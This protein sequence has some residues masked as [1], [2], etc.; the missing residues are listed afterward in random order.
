MDVPLY[1]IA[2][3]FF[4][5][6]YLAI[7]I[8]LAYVLLVTLFVMLAYLAVRHGKLP[9]NYPHSLGDTL[10][11][12]A[13][14]GVTWLIFVELGPKNPI[15]WSGSGL[16][17]SPSTLIPIDSIIEAALII[18]IIFVIILSFIARD[19]SGAGPG[20]GTSTESRPKQGVGA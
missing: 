7:G 1:A 2:L 11:T 16:T 10:I 12:V 14:I 3:A 19:L 17:Y 8:F 13:F 15:P 18:S 9:D 20:S 4:A 5:I 6:L